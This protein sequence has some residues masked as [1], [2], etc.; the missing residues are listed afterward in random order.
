MKIKG[1]IRE[2]LITLPELRE[3][4]LTI[5]SSRLEK[6]KEMSYEFRRSI[7]HANQMAHSS[8]EKSKELV[9]ILQKL[10]KVSPE[11]AFRLVN[12]MPRTKDEVRAIFTKDKY[13]HTAEEIEAIIEL[14][15]THY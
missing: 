1:V 2:D 7:E 5:E 13:A 6:E 11:V 14:I 12:T 3:E 8:R 9:E 15:I 10:E 4:L